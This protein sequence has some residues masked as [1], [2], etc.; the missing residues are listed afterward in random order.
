MLHVVHCLGITAP[1]LQFAFTFHV[2]RKSLNGHCLHISLF[3]VCFTSQL[4]SVVGPPGPRVYLRYRCLETQDN[5]AHL[6]L[7][8]SGVFW[9]LLYSGQELPEMKLLRT[10]KFLLL[11]FACLLKLLL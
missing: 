10:T 6:S 4:H 1:Y 2:Y 9:P 11:Q 8:R 7:K 5:A 3:Q